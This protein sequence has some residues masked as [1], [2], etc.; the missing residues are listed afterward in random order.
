M[1]D[2]IEAKWGCIGRVVFH[3]LDATARDR[4]GMICTVYPRVPLQGEYVLNQCVRA[5]QVAQLLVPGQCHRLYLSRWGEEGEQ[6]ECWIYT[7]HNPNDTGVHLGHKYW[8]EVQLTA[9]RQIMETL[10][11][12]HDFEVRDE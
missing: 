10:G 3:K 2:A 5:L 12:I 6:N 11:K 8:S 4:R 1:T 7:S 9:F